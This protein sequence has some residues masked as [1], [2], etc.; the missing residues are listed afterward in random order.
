MKYRPFEKKLYV[1]A[2]TFAE[3]KTFCKMADLNP[4]LDCK[5]YFSEYQLRGMLAKNIWVV[6]YTQPE[7][8]KNLLEHYYYISA[9][10]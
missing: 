5:Y 1:I 3:Y 6:I 7:N 2:N 10:N 4:Y 9:L 8:Y